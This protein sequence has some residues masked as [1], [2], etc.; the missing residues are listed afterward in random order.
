MGYL[1]KYGGIWGD[2]PDTAGRILWVA[3]ASSYT[4]E[5]RSYTASDDND[6]LSPERA[7]LTLDSAINSTTANVGDVI[8]LLPGAHSWSASAALDIAG[9]TILGLPYMPQSRVSRGVSNAKP[10]TSI[11]T[12]AS[13]EIINITAADCEIIN[14]VIIPVTALTGIDLT[15]AADRT[16]FRDCWFDLKTPV[17]AAAT[18]GVSIVGQAYTAG[19][20]DLYFGNCVF[21]EENF[22]TSQG[23]G[24][25]IGS[26]LNFVVEN[27]TFKVDGRSSNGVAAAAWSVAIQ[28]SS[29]ATG[30][31]RDCDFLTS[32]AVAMTKAITG[33]DSGSASGIGILRCFG[34]DD[35]SKLVDDFGAG[36]AYIAG[37]YISV[38]GDLVAGQSLV[39]AVT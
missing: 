11:T 12:S 36:D 13:D 17:G 18:R 6:G 29:G 25:A 26:A 4:V 3:P 7:K 8:A 15:S 28:S 32:D 20:D 33:V 1:N 24:A 9:V 22:G 39:T 30:V 5:G 10:K 37:N 38:L 21:E 19:V 2:V 23:P 16:T 34:S 31:Y 27:C 14:L 35:V